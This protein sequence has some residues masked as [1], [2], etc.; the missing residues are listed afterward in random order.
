MDSLGLLKSLSSQTI[1]SIGCSK[2]QIC[3][4]SD[5]SKNSCIS[6][7]NITENQYNSMIG[8]TIGEI[9]KEKL[10]PGNVF[11][12]LFGGISRFKRTPEPDYE[13]VTPSGNSEDVRSK[14]KD[15]EDV[16]KDKIEKILKG[17]EEEEGSGDS[18]D[19]R[20]LKFRGNDDSGDVTGSGAASEDVTSSRKFRNPEFRRLKNPE[21]VAPSGSFKILKSRVNNDS[22]G[23]GESPEDGTSSGNFENSKIERREDSEDVKLSE[24]FK[25]SKSRSNDDSEGSG[26]PPEDVTPLETLKNPE[27]RGDDDSEDVTLSGNSETS[28]SRGNDESEDDTGSGDNLEDVT[29]SR[30]SKNPKIEIREDS[31]DIDFP[32][33]SEIPK[34]KENDDSED[35]TGSG[36][37]PE[38]VTPSEIPKSSNSKKC[39]TSG[40]LVTVDGVTIFICEDS[41][42]VTKPSI[43]NSEVSKFLS[44][45]NKTALEDS[46]KTNFDE[47]LNFFKTH[48]T[49]SESSDDDVIQ[50]LLNSTLNSTILEYGASFLDE[51]N[52][53]LKKKILEILPHLPQEFTVF[54]LLEKLGIQNVPESLIPFLESLKETSGNSNSSKSPE[55]SKIVQE[56]SA[57]DSTSLVSDFLEKNP[58]ILANF[59]F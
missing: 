4:F 7:L 51:P 26:E 47:A 59:G 46:S 30:S 48:F 21:D 27:S 57:S 16:R 17:T 41:E 22:E 10:S 18:E 36:A 35:V 25:T 15:L 28:T 56:L 24:S 2:F 55:L 5:L 9:L 13:E 19:V 39:G 3:S 12:A 23:S 34:F 40:N 29:P 14:L 54:Q 11:G 58:T 49:S 44:E 32:R 53:G 6:H 33:S 1:G 37:P 31:E 42:D 50:N 20:S 52:S 43:H 45:I 38:D 8:K